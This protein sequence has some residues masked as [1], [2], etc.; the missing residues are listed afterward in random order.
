MISELR[1]DEILDFLMNSEFEDDFSPSELKYLLLKWKNFYRILY[2]TIERD[3][4][5]HDGD[6]KNL[7]SKIELNSNEIHNLKKTLSEKEIVI[8]DLKERKLSWKE[9]LTGKIISKNE[10]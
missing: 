2:C 8:K 1:D 4:T 7:Q 5:K 6:V 9:R 3:R 10:N